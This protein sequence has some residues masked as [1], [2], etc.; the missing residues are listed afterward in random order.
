MS[1]NGKIQ[2]L[3]P[4]LCTVKLFLLKALGLAKSPKDKLVVNHDGVII[5][6]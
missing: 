1:V 3:L 4:Y 5:W 6:I 2:T